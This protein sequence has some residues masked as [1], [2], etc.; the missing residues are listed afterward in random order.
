MTGYHNCGCYPKGGWSSKHNYSICNR[1]TFP[2]T[3][4][5]VCQEFS[6][7]MTLNS[8]SFFS[9]AGSYL[10]KYL[11]WATKTKGIIKLTTWK[12]H[13]REPSPAQ[14]HCSLTTKCETKA[15]SAKAP[16][17][18][19]KQLHILHARCYEHLS[20]IIHAYFNV[21]CLFKWKLLLNLSLINLPCSFGPSV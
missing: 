14:K 12:Q 7:I 21:K 11:S 15:A 4:T 20:L 16:F 19:Q 18:K 5:P 13:L 8:W 1:L 10:F 9:G 17:C 6:Q 3:P 2:G